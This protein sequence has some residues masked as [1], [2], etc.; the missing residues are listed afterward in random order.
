MSDYPLPPIAVKGGRAGHYAITHDLELAA[1]VLK[2]ASD[3]L[4]YAGGQM[5]QAHGFALDASS[6]ALNEV[7]PSVLGAQHAVHDTRVGS[8]GFNA[9]AT[10]FEAVSSS[11]V[12]VARAY[13]RAEAAAYQGV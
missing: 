3:E 8:S 10:E 4:H 11:L 12:E 6:A 1:R 2:E 7:R 13:E 5:D 9:I